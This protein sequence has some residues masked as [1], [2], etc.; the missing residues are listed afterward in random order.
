MKT[1]KTLALLCLLPAAAFADTAL[2]ARVSELETRLTALETQ[3]QPLLK[4]QAEKAHWEKKRSDARARMH[5]DGQHFERNELREIEK[6]Y[7]AGSKK[8]KTDEGKAILK[9][10]V[11][12]Y[13]KAN[14]TGCAL[15]YLGQQSTGEDQLVFLNSA[16]ND[17]SDC[18]YGDGVQVGPYAKLVLIRIYLKDAK[19]DAAKKLIKSIRS[20][21]LDAISHNGK[22]LTHLLD[23]IPKEAFQPGSSNNVQ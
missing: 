14:R 4:E 9:D 16:I 13:P 17:F 8:W 11:E 6:L 1:L 19:I 2:E 20:E 10:L 23:R 3:L 7:Q 21:H 22:R 12:K 5:A 15:L 18:Y